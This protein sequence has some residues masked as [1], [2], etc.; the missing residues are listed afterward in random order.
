[1][2]KRMIAQEKDACAIIAFVDKRGRATHANIV[3]TIDALKKMAHRSGDIDNE[4]DGCGIL[5]DLPRSLWGRRLEENDLSRHLADS[6]NFFVGHL[7]LP[8]HLGGR[9]QAIKDKVRN[10]FKEKGLTILAEVSGNTRDEELGPLARFEA[11]LFWQICGLVPGE[12]LAKCRNLLFSLQMAIEA[13]EPE[14]HIASL[15]PDA[16]VYK[17]RGTPDLLPRVYPELLDGKTR[18]VLTLGHSRYSTNTLP[19]VELSQPFS[20]LGHNGEIN[21]IEKLRSAG[22]ALGIEPVPGGSDS[23]DLN[24]IIEG[25]INRYGFDPL[26]AVETLFPAIHSQVAQYVPDLQKVYDFYRWFFPPSAQG[27]AAVVARFGH[28]CVGSVDA[29]GLR[30]LWFGES[31]YDYFLSSEK[32]VVNLQDTACDPRPM[33]PGEKVAILA[34]LGQRAEVLDY[35]RYQGRL[36]RLAGARKRLFATVSN[37]HKKIPDA[38]RNLNEGRTP[39]IAQFRSPSTSKETAAPHSTLESTTKKATGASE[40]DVSQA[41]MMPAEAVEGAPKKVVISKSSVEDSPHV[42]ITPNILKAFGWQKYDQEMRKSVAIT[43]DGPIGSMGYQGALACI[44]P[45]SLPNISDFFKENVAVVTNPAIDR[46]REA[47]HFSTRVIL[48]ARPD[49][50]DMDPPPMALEL[51]TPI[52]LGGDAKGH[53]AADDLS[54]LCGKHGTTTLEQVL[55]FFTSGLRDPSKV[56]VLDA[57]F[58]VS[59][60]LSARLDKLI[61]EAEDAITRGAVLLILDDENSFSDGRCFIDPGLSVAFLVKR[62][63]EMRLR[64]RCAIIVRS[65][66]IRN[67]HDIMFLLGLGADAV[68]PHMLWKQACA[69]A[70]NEE[71]LRRVLSNTL[72]ALQKGMEKVMSTMGIHELCGYGRIFSA[73]GLSSKLQEIFQCTGFCVHEKTGLSFATLEASA[74]LRL[75]AAA[76]GEKEK[77]WRDPKRNPKVG[78]VLRAVALGRSGYAQMEAGMAE[79]DRDH[80]VALRHLLDFAGIEE[81]GPVS[82]DQVEIGAGDHSMPLVISAMSFGSQGENSFRTYATA[83]QK[84]NIVCING[85]GGEIPDMLGKY[86]ANRGQQIAS[87]RFGVSMALLNS[88]DFLEIKVGQGAKPG[89]GGHLPGSKVTEMV[90]KARH[91]KPGIGLISPS[92]HHDIYSIEDLCQIITEL[93]TANPKARISVKIPVTG[94]VGT[95]AVG[96]AKA[97]AHI[98]NISGFDGGTGAAREHA[99]KYVGLPAEIGVTQAHRALVESGLRDR[100]EI[101][102]DGGMRSG[103]DVVKMICLGADRVGLGTVA[104]MGIGCI[105]CER[106]HLDS[107]PMGISTQLTSISE[108]RDRGVKGFSVLDRMSESENLARLLLAIGDQIRAILARMGRTVLSEIVGRTDLLSQVRGKELV[109]LEDLLLPA[110]IEGERNASPTPR[111]IRTPLNNLTR[112]ISGMA[113]DAFEDGSGAVHYREENIRSVD[114]AVGTFLAGEMTRQGINRK[115]GLS[116]RALSAELQFHASVPGNG[117]CAFGIEGIDTIVEGGGQDG[118]AKGSMGGSTCVLKGRNLMGQLVDGSVGKSA[119]Y[120]AIGG[121]LMVQNFAD[122]RACIRMSGADAIF[123][124]RITRTVRDELGNIAV[125]AHLKGFAFEYMTGGRVVVLGDPGP[126]LCA[127]MTGGVIYQCLY[128]EHNFTE[129]SIKRRIARGASVSISALSEEDIKTVR[130]LLGKY[131]EKLRK[132]FQ[133]EEAEAVKFLLE[134]AMNRFVK[135]VPEGAIA[136]VAE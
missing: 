118:I 132:G 54:A 41:P 56:A 58:D 111:R 38:F 45:E 20:L 47:E 106:C 96:V 101:W 5:T 91:C 23:Q 59:S 86:R 103:A 67:L 135:I 42:Q 16:V 11:P 133:T 62:F 119:A 19:T 130:E 24:R 10:I 122:S 80:P 115:A 83:A 57:T 28:V 90:A 60:G 131:M 102:C 74:R 78:K 129:E 126:W 73:I 26:E 33:A 108:A 81:K 30:P 37:L 34:G 121:T 105:S 63:E 27:P 40:E 53:I 112:L 104:L 31:D 117:L 35:S 100:V 128:P 92:N 113:M 46:E 120:G 95:I 68:N 61:K 15:S 116:P 89:E 55:D 109:D 1:M 79:I 107:C 72:S 21:T 70:K 18:S 49:S 9:G 29:L 87:G 7:F 52:L 48:G 98:V 71:G 65:G 82:L 124:A 125:R 2:K 110:A 77:L 3:K 12:G 97:G 43:G 22:K 93:T 50:P 123:G 127:G 32:G 17:V 51:A 25:L 14:L 134:D 64:R 75:T 136:A 69:Q 39:T 76:S 114:R 84:V 66:A 94:G 13:S 99:K 88:A 8:H 6:R 4:G 44:N 36:V 85:E